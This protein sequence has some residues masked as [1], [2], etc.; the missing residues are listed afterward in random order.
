MPSPSGDLQSYEEIVRVLEDMPVI[1]R[2]TRRRWG[3][4]LRAAG[5][6][7]DVSAST[8]MR[9]E[10]GETVGL[11]VPGLAAILRWAAEPARLPEEGQ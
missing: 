4:S 8:L 6:H 11:G 7:L 9:W 1:L 2:E 3:M 10:R 5:T